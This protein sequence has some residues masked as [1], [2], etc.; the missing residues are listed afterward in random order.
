MT[1]RSKIELFKI[2]FQKRKAFI[3]EVAAIERQH[4]SGFQEE[5][6]PG[7]AEPGAPRGRRGR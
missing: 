4:L 1:R 2:A 6:G 7:R 3:F 5:E